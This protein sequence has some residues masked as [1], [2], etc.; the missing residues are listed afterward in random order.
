MMDYLPPPQSDWADVEGYLIFYP[1]RMPCS[2]HSQGKTR[3]LVVFLSNPT[4]CA[5]S[6]EGLYPL[7]PIRFPLIFQI[8][9]KGTLKRTILGTIRYSPFTPPLVGFVVRN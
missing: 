9:M 6:M 7:C 2:L 3:N 4:V 5:L 1:M 8:F